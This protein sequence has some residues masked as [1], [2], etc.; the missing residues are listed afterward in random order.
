MTYIVF[1]EIAWPP[2]GATAPGQ[3]A[4]TAGLR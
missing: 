1:H 4:F 2:R 3:A